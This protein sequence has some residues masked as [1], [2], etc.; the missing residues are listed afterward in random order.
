VTPVS[1]RRALGLGVSTGLARAAPGLMLGLAA[2][3]T[4]LCT[5]LSWRSGLAAVA[6]P[7]QAARFLCFLGATAAAWL[8]EATVLGG[9]VRQ[10]AAFLRA[11]DVPTL[12]EAMAAALQRSLRW[13]VLAGAAVFAW[14]G[15]QL[16]VGASG[17]L[18]F[19]RGLLHGGGGLTGALGLSLAF[20]LG[21][22]GA[23]L[24]QLVVEMALVRSVLR[25]E[26]ASV[27]LWEAARALLARP[28]VPLALLV[29][30]AVLAVAVSGLAAA[31]VGMAPPSALPLARGAALVE[32]SIA[33]LASAVALL[34]RLDAF[35]ALELD[36]TGELPPAVGRAEPSVPRAEL[37]LDA[38]P[39]LEAR[40]VGP[41]QP[42]GA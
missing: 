1:F 7:G 4:T 38:E 27:A 34:V 6:G 28:W 24:L 14:T 5:T 25:D 8:L 26:P 22:L 19:L 30:T 3:A 33:S 10:G 2:L 42:G 15:W 18:L 37:L 23:V 29:V 32:L 13:A 36:R 20:T 16:L 39:V 41:S 17:L 12:R 9:A 35:L 11:G 31:V 21:P 40:A